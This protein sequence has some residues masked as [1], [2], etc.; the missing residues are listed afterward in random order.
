MTS[1][2]ACTGITAVASDGEGGEG[3]C[4]GGRRGEVQG[5]E[6]RG[7]AREGGEGRCKGGRRG[8]VQGREERGG[9]REGGE[10]RC[11]GGR[12]GEVQGREERGGAR[13]GGEGRC[14]GGRRGEVQGREERGGAREG[15]EGRCKGGRRGEVQGREERGGAREGG[16]GRCKGGRRGEVQGSDHEEVILH[17]VQRERGGDREAT[18]THNALRTSRNVNGR[19]F[20]SNNIATSVAT[21]IAI[22]NRRTTSGCKLQPKS[23]NYHS[24]IAVGISFHG[25]SPAPFIFRPSQ[26]SV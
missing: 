21:N 17:A 4:K 15:G 12:R 3:R 19:P 11:K 13:E 22:S 16:E 25:E 26:I 8:E 18:G 2:E 7:G 10:G 9:A 24:L 5:R 23:S 6:E 20:S 1:T 14:K